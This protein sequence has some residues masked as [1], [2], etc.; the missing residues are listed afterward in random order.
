MR[1]A[2]TMMRTTM[3]PSRLLSTMAARSLP[4]ALPV[5]LQTMR[6]TRQRRPR[7]LQHQTEMTMTMTMQRK[8]AMS[9]M[10]GGFSF[11]SPRKLEEI[12]KLDKLR[13]E[14]SNDIVAIW[15]AR[16]AEQKGA[17]GRTISQQQFDLVMARS[18]E[19]PLFLF[20]VRRKA[21]ENGRD[22]D[23]FFVV[24]TQFQDKMCLLTGLEEFRANPATAP[25]YAILNFYDELLHPP[26]ASVP[27]VG[28]GELIGA[29]THDIVLLRMDLVNTVLTKDDGDRLLQNV[30][31]FYTNQAKL[32]DQTVH[33]FNHRQQ[34]F[35]LN[36]FLRT[37]P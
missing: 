1:T 33:A 10:A 37:C 17:I 36:E 29:K 5:T 21:G 8:T 15:K 27:G 2:T 19:S 23:S 13:R 20:P 4:A 3:A 26:Q 16:H 30:V 7:L 24:I 35:D 11:P 9:T 32:Y 22:T 28:Q 34:D 31:R 12:V 25:P 18:R 6:R 14:E